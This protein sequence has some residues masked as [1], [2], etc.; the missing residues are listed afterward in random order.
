M[1]SR[2]WKWPGVCLDLGQCVV[3]W[4]ETLNT[5]RAIIHLKEWE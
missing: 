1:M 4:D 3:F 5:H 2:E